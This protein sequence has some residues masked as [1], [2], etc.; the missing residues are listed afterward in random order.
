MNNRASLNPPSD[1]AFGILLAVVLV[2]V[3]GYQLHRGAALSSV[4]TLFFLS[5]TIF[6]IALFFSRLLAPFNRAWL[7]L[8]DILGKLVNPIVLAIIFFILL[9]PVAFLSR[10][11]G[12]D[13]L[14]LKPRADDS[15]WIDRT[16]PGPAAD[17]FK[18]QY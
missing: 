4:K 18:N 3:G 8:G 6:F 14:K 11:L 7:L 15:Y 12:R 17:S 1:R 5:I 16:P 10:I 13:E 9:S 2:C